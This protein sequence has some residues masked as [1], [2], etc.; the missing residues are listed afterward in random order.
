M[1]QR[2]RK[3]ILSR[4]MCRIACPRWQYTVAEAD[5]GIDFLTRALEEITQAMTAQTPPRGE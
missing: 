2:R 5:W 4:L 1:K 3:R